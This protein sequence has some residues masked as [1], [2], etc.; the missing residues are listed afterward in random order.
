MET[1]IPT[2]PYDE[3][4]KLTQPPISRKSSSSSSPSSSGGSSTAAASRAAKSGNGSGS[5]ATGSHA[6]STAGQQHHHNSH[7]ASKR[8]GTTP[9]SSHSHSHHAANTASHHS[10][11]ATVAAAA[12]AAATAATHSHGSPHHDGDGRHKRVWKACERCRMKKT[13]CD[14]E[15]PCK[16]CKDDG[17]V[18]TAGTRKKTEYKQLPKG[19]AEVLENTQF[20]LV[21]TVHKLYAMVRAAHAWDLGEPELNERGQPVIHSIA[22]KLGCIRPNNDPDLPMGSSVFPENEQ[23]LVELASQLDDHQKKRDAEQAV[24]AAAA[25]AAAAVQAEPTQQPQTKALD[26]ATT[27][28]TTANAIPITMSSS[29][30]TTTMMA[31]NAAG[32][33]D[34]NLS[35]RYERA[36]SSEDFDGLSDMDDYRKSVFGPSNGPS[37]SV[38]S[39][40]TTMSP[41]SL[42]FN[43]FDVGSNQSDGFVAPS[44]TLPSTQYT[45]WM[46]QTAPMDMSPNTPLQQTQAQSQLMQLQ[47][48]QQQQQQRQQ[49]QIQQRQ[50]QRQQ[51]QQRQQM[52]QQQQHNFKQVP[53][54]LSIP[55]SMAAASMPMLGSNS[56]LYSADLLRQG[57]LESNFGAMEPHI[58][59]ADMPDVMLG[60]GDPMIYGGDYDDNML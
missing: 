45:N 31:S 40:S 10:S 55:T 46:T 38:N 16:R 53:L 32:P 17:L 2:P 36:S 27:A 41:Q 57:L 26:A 59:S 52:L 35:G 56:T 39:A 3:Q 30:P 44:P 5:N 7:R 18:C 1:G 8:S 22:S 51:Q 14:G 20:A 60:M 54:S 23:D 19:Y 12:A 47:L 25:A 29:L 50:R 58:M 11:T 6:H 9:T 49:Q 43:D 34:F 21:A 48:Q 33:I 4:N 13:K 15:F 24:T 28:A 42:N 37:S